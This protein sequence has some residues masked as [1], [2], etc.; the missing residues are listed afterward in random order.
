MVDKTT[1]SPIAP[2]EVRTEAGA[3]VARDAVAVRATACAHPEMKARFPEP[4]ALGGRGPC[5][6]KSGH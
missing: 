1:G 3:P 6:S 4:V 2:L 5:G